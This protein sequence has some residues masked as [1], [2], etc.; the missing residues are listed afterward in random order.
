MS[1][2][3][4]ATA[5]FEA[6]PM[7]KK[8]VE[9][10]LKGK[11][12]AQKVSAIARQLTNHTDPSKIMEVLNDNPALLVEFYKK[13]ME[14][15]KEMYLAMLTDREHARSRTSPSSSRFMLFLFLSGLASCLFLLALGNLSG[16][17]TALLSTAS[18]IFG[19]C[20]KDIYAFEFSGKYER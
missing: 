5:L 19:A 18:G 7:L 1:A 16:E 8:L 20:L 12:M 2:L 4:I 10:P 13:L 11:D 14:T 6:V 15:V 17:V 9:H 3:A